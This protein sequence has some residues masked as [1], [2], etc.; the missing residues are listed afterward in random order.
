MAYI[1]NRKKV[2]YLYIDKKDEE[3]ITVTFSEKFNIVNAHISEILRKIRKNNLSVFHV[4]NETP[5][6]LLLY[7]KPLYLCMKIPV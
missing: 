1:V 5:Y 3:N 4:S 6:E 2:E 7:Q